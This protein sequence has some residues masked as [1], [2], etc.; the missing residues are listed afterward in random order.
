MTEVVSLV[1]EPMWKLAL[2]SHVS[3]WSLP[4]YINS[5]GLDCDMIKLQV[6]VLSLN[7]LNGVQL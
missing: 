2:Q 1:V 6:W 5:T 4:L 3:A 7:E